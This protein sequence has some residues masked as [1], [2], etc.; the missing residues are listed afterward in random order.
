MI[1]VSPRLS[2]ADYCDGSAVAGRS[3]SQRELWDPGWRHLLKASIVFALLVAYRTELFPE[4]IFSDAFTVQAADV[5]GSVITLRAEGLFDTETG[6]R[7]ALI[8]RWRVRADPS[9]RGDQG[10]HGASPPPVGPSTS[11]SLVPQRLGELLRPR[12]TSRH[13]G[14]V[15]LR[16]VRR[17][18]TAHPGH[19]VAAVTARD[20]P[21][22]GVCVQR[23]IPPSYILWTQIP[24]NPPV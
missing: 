4:E 14:G 10:E 19:A 3:N 16:R 17:P 23:Q 18:P 21:V 7:V 9:D 5:M 2:C 8:V 15:G 11:I 6:I 13:V 12:R 1:R 20:A 24:D 22:N